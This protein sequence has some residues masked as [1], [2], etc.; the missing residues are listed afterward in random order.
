MCKVASTSKKYSTILHT[1]VWYCV[2][3][4]MFWVRAGV[5][6]AFGH[7]PSG[8]HA[9]HYF[10]EA[11]RGSATPM[12][13]RNLSQQREGVG[14]SLPARCQRK[15]AFHFR[16]SVETNNCGHVLSSYSS[17]PLQFLA[18]Y[19]LLTVSPERG[20]GEGAITPTAGAENRRI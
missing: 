11:N 4:R 1:P 6:T 12:H 9:N 14:W 16:W 7:T 17:T 15:N 18:Y 13:N 3:V 5:R 10:V 8:V 19:D 20:R 2:Q